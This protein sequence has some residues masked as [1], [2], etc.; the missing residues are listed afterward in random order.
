V[1]A[2]DEID[3]DSRHYAE[4]KLNWATLDT[5]TA[6]NNKLIA[7]DQTLEKIDGKIDK[8]TAWFLGTTSSTG[9]Q[10]L[11]V[12]A[13]VQ[14]LWGVRLAVITLIGAIAVAT[15]TNATLN[16]IDHV[17]GATTTT[18]QGHH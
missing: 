11:G 4:G 18:S 7:H 17:T 16:I 14:W 12:L 2:E 13:K 1:P 6:I 5:V 10:E 8:L 9:V 15:A 3:R